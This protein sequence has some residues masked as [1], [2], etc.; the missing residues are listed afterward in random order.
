MKALPYL[1]LPTHMRS[2]AGVMLEGDTEVN[3]LHGLYLKLQLT[4]HVLRTNVSCEP[5][6]TLS[7]TLLC[8]GWP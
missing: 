5:W 8:F 6:L 7:Y 3:C 4:L 2:W 1:N